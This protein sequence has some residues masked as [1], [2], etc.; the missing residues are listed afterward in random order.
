MNVVEIQKD[1]VTISFTHS[2]LLDV[3]LS[4]KI[5]YDVLRGVKSPEIPV[6]QSKKDIVKLVK[7]IGP[8]I[9][10]LGRMSGFCQFVG[11]V[12]EKR[13]LFVLEGS[14]LA[15]ADVDKPVA[16]HFPADIVPILNRLNYVPCIDIIL[17]AILGH[18]D[19]FRV[20]FHRRQGWIGDC[21]V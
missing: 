8:V 18:A 12:E 20:A 17:G 9:K 13:F 3:L 7:S 2:E 1:T 4:L 5:N 15:F 10:D 16:V 6:V 14:E 11:I 19:K 21:R